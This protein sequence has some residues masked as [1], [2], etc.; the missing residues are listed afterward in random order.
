MLICKDKIGLRYNEYMLIRDFNLQH[1]FIDLSDI[2]VVPKCKQYVKSI[3]KTRSIFLNINRN[4]DLYYYALG[5]NVL[6]YYYEITK[7]IQE[8]IFKYKDKINSHKIYVKLFNNIN[9]LELLINTLEG[10]KDLYRKLYVLLY[11]FIPERLN[12]DNRQNIMSF[13]I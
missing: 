4:F 1:C 12:H 9:C 7:N 6:T 10:Y 13:L 3:K 8:N 2:F 11:S 5:M